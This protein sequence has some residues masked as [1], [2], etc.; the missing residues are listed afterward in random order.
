MIADA[1][2]DTDYYPTRITD[3]DPDADSEYFA[4]AGTDTDADTIYLYSYYIS[5]NYLHV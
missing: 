1:D 5:R 4:D 3:A 2:A